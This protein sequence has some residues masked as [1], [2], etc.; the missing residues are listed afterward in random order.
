MWRNLGTVAL[1][2]DQATTTALER[3]G[4][5]SQSVDALGRPGE[6]DGVIAHHR[7]AAQRGKADV[8]RAPP[9]GHAVAGGHAAGTEAG[10]AACTRVGQAARA[11]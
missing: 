4:D 3:S 11:E 2:L 7:A 9:A 6:D 10:Q 5:F 8:A 1:V